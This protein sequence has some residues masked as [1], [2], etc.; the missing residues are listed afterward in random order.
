MSTTRG[1]NKSRRRVFKGRR[2]RTGPRKD[3]AAFPAAPPYRRVIR[4]QGRAGAVNKKRELFPEPAS[5]SSASLASPLS[6]HVL[7]REY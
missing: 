2:G 5:T 7:V 3:Y 6:I 4:F 1:A